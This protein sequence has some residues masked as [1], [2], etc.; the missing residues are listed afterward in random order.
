MRTLIMKGKSNHD[1]G[2]DIAGGNRGSDQPISA[3]RNDDYLTI[4][5]RDGGIHL[6]GDLQMKTFTVHFVMKDTTYDRW[7]EKRHEIAG[8]LNSRKEIEITTD[9]HDDMYYL[10]KVTNHEL[11]EFPT[12]TSVAFGVEFTVQPFMYY[13]EPVVDILSFSGSTATYI[14]KS[15]YETAHTLKITVQT[16]S[17]NLEVGVNGEKLTFDHSIRNG[18]IITIDTEKRELRLND[19]LK[20]LEVD[21]VF[22]KLEPGTNLIT[23]TVTGP[24]EIV[25]R[26]QML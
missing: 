12:S 20:V 19:E 4:P 9:E 2:L 1:L 8:W 7:I 21:G 14:N 15:N 6:P 11:P 24:H 5:G 18:D 25:F 16:A 3:L 17:S 26:G 22:E 13:E 10:G 23:S